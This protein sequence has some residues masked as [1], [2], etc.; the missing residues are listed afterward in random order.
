M[1][2]SSLVLPRAVMRISMRVSRMQ[3][4]AAFQLQGACIRCCL[5]QVQH[6][7]CF[8]I[9]RLLP[10]PFFLRIGTLL[11]TCDH[12]P[13]SAPICSHYWQSCLWYPE[14]NLI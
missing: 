10:Y 8:S 6:I 4:N 13:I 2:P 5:R 3:P 9:V 12:G 1:L 11:L 7:R 14:E